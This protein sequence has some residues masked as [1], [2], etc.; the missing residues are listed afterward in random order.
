LDFGDGS[1]HSSSFGRKCANS[2]ER[3]PVPNVATKALIDLIFH[4]LSQ[5][6]KNTKG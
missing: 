1:M 3:L 5:E 2:Y 6:S 4:V